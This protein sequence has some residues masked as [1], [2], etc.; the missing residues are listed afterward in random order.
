VLFP[1]LAA[2]TV[3]VPGKHFLGNASNCVSSDDS[4]SMGGTEFDT[5]LAFLSNTSDFSLFFI[6]LFCIR[7]IFDVFNSFDL[8]VDL[9]PISMFF[10]SHVE[11][12]LTLDLVCASTIA[13]SVGEKPFC[14]KNTNISLEQVLV[15]VLTH[16][17]LYDKSLMLMSCWSL[18][19]GMYNGFILATLCRIIAGF[20]ERATEK[21]CLD[22]C[23]L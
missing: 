10:L 1:Y 5:V 14:N 8:N 18:G 23:I 16:L 21:K 15:H 17:L 11:T 13:T 2:R 22:I 12:G 20:E 7:R 3:V 9:F 19:M 4:L 6:L